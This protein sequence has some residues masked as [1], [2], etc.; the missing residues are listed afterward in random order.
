MTYILLILGFILLVKGA[1]YLVDGASSV[2]ANYNIS[3]LIIG[4]TIVAFGTS[5]PE[6]IVNILASLSGNPEIAIGNIVGSN[7]ANILLIL[8]ISAII[9][10]LKVKNS[11][12]WRE[13]P[14]SLLAVVVLFLLVTNFTIDLN[15]GTLILTRMGGAVL[16]LFF[17]FFMFY[18]IRSAKSGIN[19]EDEIQ[20]QKRSNKK[21][22]LLI[23]LGLSGLVIGGHLIVESA[24]ELAIEMGLSKSFIGLTIVAI[25][26]S[27]PELA[28]S[29][30]AAYKKNT[31]IA[32]GNIVGSN[33]F[34]IFWIL[35][36]SALINPLPLSSGNIFDILVAFLSTLLLFIFIFTGKGRTINRIEG[37]IFVVLYIGYLLF[38]I[39]KI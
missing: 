21:S 38:L 29:A 6:L 23:V 28:T 10:P 13:V 2:A 20:P 5:T 22:T 24:S 27:L 18:I 1:D 30:I 17:A 16:I 31:D 15:S 25:G 8:G 37:I 4:L 26:T 34:N 32:I 12:T 33:I 9:F 14:F 7:I 36:V 3:G 19:D 35:G 11:I 39:S